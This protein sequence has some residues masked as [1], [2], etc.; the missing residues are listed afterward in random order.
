MQKNPNKL[1]LIINALNLRINKLNGPPNTMPFYFL[2]CY[3]VFCTVSPPGE[4]ISRFLCFFGCLSNSSLRPYPLAFSTIDPSEFSNTSFI[5]FD[6]SDFSCSMCG[7][8]INRS[9]VWLPDA[10]LLGA[11]PGQV[12]HICASDTNNTNWYQ[13]RLGGLASHW[14]CVSDMAS[15]TTFRVKVNARNVLY[16][17]THTLSICF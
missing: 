14:Q 3:A 12:L 10:P 17:P 15:A 7:L 6:L 8:Q 16:Q 13:C 1:S 5:I 4:Q 9:R 2:A 11:N